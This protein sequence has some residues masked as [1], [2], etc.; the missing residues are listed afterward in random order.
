MLLSN[1]NTPTLG[2]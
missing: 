1:K 2:L